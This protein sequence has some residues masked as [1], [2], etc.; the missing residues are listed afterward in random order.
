MPEP[1]SLYDLAIERIEAAPP[2]DRRAAFFTELEALPLFSRD[3]VDLV[4]LARARF[5]R[6]PYEPPEFH[7]LAGFSYPAR[8]PYTPDETLAF[9]EHAAALATIAEAKAQWEAALVSTRRAKHAQGPES[10][11]GRNPQTA[12]QLETVR[13]AVEAERAALEAYEGAKAL[14]VLSR[15]HQKRRL[16]AGPHREGLVAR[17]R[18]TLAG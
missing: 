8:G 7:V 5:A 18:R 10:A 9:E 12:A 4:L 13:A 1:K 6:G 14:E 11:S 3:R 15:P 16:P 17:L 2:D